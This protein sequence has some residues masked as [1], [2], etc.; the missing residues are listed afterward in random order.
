[1]SGCRLCQLGTRP[2]L[3]EGPTDAKILWIGEAPGAAEVVFGRPF[4][5]PAGQFLRKN[6][7][8]GPI[9]ENSFVTNLLCCRPREGDHNAIPTPEQIENCR[10]HLV[11]L[12]DILQP[13][14]IIFVG[15]IAQL[16]IAPHA[17]KRGIWYSQNV[18]HLIDANWCNKA[19]IIHI[20][21][22]SYI[23][24]RGGFKVR[25]RDHH[26]QE[27]YEQYENLR[28]YLLEFLNEN[29]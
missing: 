10:Y 19:S 2:I 20:Y 5:G 29:L 4:I 9:S 23:R 18:P 6:L 15:R 14:R 13:L 27:A 16:V 26:V 25:D 22:P 17:A 24:R 11:Y 1:M 28:S 21:H 12:L 7:L 8:N 3:G